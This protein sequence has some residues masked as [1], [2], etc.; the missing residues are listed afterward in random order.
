MQFVHGAVRSLVSSGPVRMQ[1]YR[2]LVTG[3]HG[4]LGS[5]LREHSSFRGWDLLTPTRRE[6][7]LCNFHAVRDYVTDH[8][9]S[10]IVH[11]AGLVGGIQA[12]IE[13]PVDFLIQN[14]DMGRNIILA[15][16][17]AQVKRVINIGSSCMY[18][19][20]HS[21]LLE[22]EHILSG[23]LEPTNEGYALAKIVASRLCEYVNR[24]RGITQCKTLI[25]CNLYGRYDSFDPR[26]SHLLPAI[27]HK[28]HAAKMAGANTVE[29]WG[30]G[31]ARREFMYAGDCADAIAKALHD[32]E[33]L[34]VVMNLGLGTD[35]SVNEY[36]ETAAE[37]IGW[38]GQFVHDVNRP[39]GMKR[40]CVSTT[41]QRAWGWGPK[42]SLK[43]GI[44][45]T[46][47]YYLKSVQP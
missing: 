47:D 20:D 28:I 31:T 23:P 45:L 30:D 8:N 41:K 10:Y 43:E 39:V 24:E 11:A 27:I 12:N 2:V 7:D 32:F 44:R 25:P 38:T 22:E 15:A 17:S 13:R 26:Y 21:G 4:M 33:T 9:V 14:L 5:N 40:K 29:I 37:V 6:L 36:Y 46:Y 16:R 34:P 18:P 42:T 1:Q 35:Y 19:R 3:A